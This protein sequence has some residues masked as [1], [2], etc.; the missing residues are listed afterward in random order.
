MQGHK[1]WSPSFK[2]EQPCSATYIL[3]CPWIRP[4]LEVTWDH[5]LLPLLPHRLLS[6][7]PLNNL[8][9]SKTVSGSASR[10]LG[11][12]QCSWE[13]QYIK[14]IKE[15]FHLYLGGGQV[16][17]TGWFSWIYGDL[18]WNFPE[19]SL[20]II[21]Q[22]ESESRSVVSDSLWPH[23]LYRPWNSPGQNTGMGSLSLL[24]G[25]FPTQGLNPGLLHCRRIL[26]SEPP[27]KP[28]NTGVGSLSL[29]QGIFPTQELNRG[30]LHYRQIL[31]QLS[32]QE[33]P[34][35]IEERT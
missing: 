6:R 30:L 28:K 7:E 11:L 12:R 35:Q 19:N 29:L 27:G 25:I 23:G 5:G 13:A 8:Y 17:V 15:L 26:W 33:S 4:R 18:R 2:A 14:Q 21:Q 24:Q 22:I 32:Y 9:A 3:E 10:K 16:M 1:P 31:Y 34:Q 20:E